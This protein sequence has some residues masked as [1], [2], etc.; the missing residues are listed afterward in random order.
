MFAPAALCTSVT[1]ACSKMPAA[2]AVVVVFPLVAETSTLPRARREPSAADR[3]CVE[4]QQHLARNARGAAAAQARE[5]RH[6]PR[7][8]ELWGQRAGHQP[9]GG[10]CPP[11]SAA[12]AAACRGEPEP[13]E[14]AGESRARRVA[15]GHQHVDRARAPRA[16]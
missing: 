16:R 11:A 8:S 2:I 1:P 15:L 5:R 14:G 10:C 13:G 7:D 6:R 12:G 3:I 4:L 9:A